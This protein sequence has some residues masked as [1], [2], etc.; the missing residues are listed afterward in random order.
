MENGGGHAS[1]RRARSFATIS[2]MLA[3][4]KAYAVGSRGISTRREASRG[5]AHNFVTHLADCCRR[6]RLHY[7]AN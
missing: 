6:T 5:Q 1:E 3:L 2:L 4:V 7:C